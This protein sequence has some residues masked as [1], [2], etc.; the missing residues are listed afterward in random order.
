MGKMVV[1]KRIRCRGQASRRL[2]R[3]T[4]AE[5]DE[6]AVAGDEAPLVLIAEDFNKRFR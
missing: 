4:D 3:P 1:M 2:R 6:N 5:V